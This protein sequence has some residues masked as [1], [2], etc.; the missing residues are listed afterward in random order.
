MA[1]CRLFIST[2]KGKSHEVAKDL[3]TM[4]QIIFVG[5][6]IG[7][8]TIRLRVESIVKDNCQILDVMEKMKAMGG[9]KDVVW[10]RL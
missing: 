5:K 1:A 9:I 4:E 7:Q 8:Q 10:V 3:L 6:S 2:H